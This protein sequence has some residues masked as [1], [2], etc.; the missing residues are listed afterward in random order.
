MASPTINRIS[1]LTA[2]KARE[3]ALEILKEIEEKGAYL[4]L[5]LKT[6]SFRGSLFPVQREPP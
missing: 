6:G 5:V 4:T 3:A 2:F 1:P